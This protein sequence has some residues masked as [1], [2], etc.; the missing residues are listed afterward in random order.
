MSPYNQRSSV[1]NSRPSIATLLLYALLLVLVV[2][3]VWR[4]WPVAPA[5]ITAR[6][7]EDQTVK[8][9]PFDYRADEKANIEL[10][11]KAKASV[12][13]ITTVAASRFRFD[14]REE[15]QGRGSGFIWDDDGHVVTNFHVI[16]DAAGA[17]VTL[18]DHTTYKADL[19]GYDRARDLAVLKLI[20]PVDLLR[21]LQPI[22]RGESA[23]LHVGQRTFA[24]G[25]PF[26]LDHTLTS[27]LVSALGRELKGD[28]GRTLK[29]MIQTD[30][31][32]NPGN[33]G[34]PLLDSAGRL[35]GV[36]TAIVSASGAS[37]GIGFAIPVDDVRRI[38]PQLIDDG[39]VTRAGL[40]GILLAP[41]QWAQQ[42]GVKGVIIQDVQA[43][44]EAARAGLQFIGR[45]NA[46]RLHL[47][48]IV[49]INGKPV[50]T[51]ND[52]FNVLEA[53]EPGVTVS[54]RI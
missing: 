40:P 15:V 54:V 32:I 12:V 42:L 4:V 48:A 39:K 27:G 10:Y 23:N 7:W 45:D 13:N 17:L 41:D 24:I 29:G 9:P 44:S 46:G 30:A 47:D 8:T 25:N 6:N 14:T 5:R 19:R 49:A 43:G 28:G 3:V 31:A 35:I 22:V 34:G 53:Y 2:V 52:M 51:Q 50:L 37:A 33:S 1:S 38:V 18:A 26:G 16:K 20:A 11:E 36:N 21:S